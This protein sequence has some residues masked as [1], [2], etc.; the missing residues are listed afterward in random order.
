M[1]YE[2]ARQL[3]AQGQTV[4]LL[5]LMDPDPPAP[6]KWS[7][8]L[9]S[10]FGNLLRLSQEKQVDCFLVY[11]YLRLSFY[12][13]RLNQRKRMRTSEQGEPGL[14]RS[15]AGALAPRLTAVIPRREVLRQDW[16]S[17]YNWVAAGY[18]P[19][20][21]PGKITFFW[22]EEEPFR[23]EEWRQVMEAKTEASEV[24]IRIIPGDHLT[25]R[26]EHLPVLAEQLRTC[27]GKA[28]ST[29]VS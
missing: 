21:Y 5:V 23:T 15:T 19:R 18:L 29:G 26:T 10:G 9:I 13:W 24:E 3:H 8:R 1:A 28:P 7:R 6:H 17:L 22:T 14:E 25:S 20:S 16:L 4:D 11:R 2:M 12:Y 27:L